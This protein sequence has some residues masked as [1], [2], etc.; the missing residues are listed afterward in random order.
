MKNILRI[1]YLKAC[2]YQL[3]VIFRNCYEE[4]GFN[5]SV[6]VG[7]LE[8][9]S[10]VADPSEVE[11]VVAGSSGLKS[12]VTD[13]S[14]V[15]LVVAGTSKVEMVVAGK[16]VGDIVGSAFHVEALE[17]INVEKFGEQSIDL[18]AMKNFICNLCPRT[19][20]SMNSLNMHIKTC[21][22]RKKFLC[23]VCDKIF[24]SKFMLA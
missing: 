3:N 1:W 17:S 4:T 15:E 16:K 8:V 23:A 7:S 6:V 22:E 10:V 18:G 11:L 19:Y 20:G 14:E 21:H 13:S 9:E 24:G 2:C 12:S 5:E